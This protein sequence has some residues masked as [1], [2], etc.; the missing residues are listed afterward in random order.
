[1]ETFDFG[2]MGHH[3]YDHA[4][5]ASDIDM[6]FP[7]YGDVTLQSPKSQFARRNM[8]DHVPF[9]RPREPHCE[10]IVP[11]DQSF[12]LIDCLSTKPPCLAHAS[13]EPISA[14]TRASTP[15]IKA[16]DD[17]ASKE[18]GTTPPASAPFGDQQSSEAHGTGVDVLMKAIQ[19]KCQVPERQLPSPP[20]T[21]SSRRDSSSSLDSSSTSGLC[22]RRRSRGKER[23]KCPVPSCGKA[24]TQ[25]G[26]L[27]VHSRAHTGH[28]PYV[29]PTAIMK[30][31]PVTD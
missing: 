3:S 14:W 15:S 30:S 11:L 26:R 17:T 21:V 19:T 10:T 13:E 28:K 1:M 24:F 9:A 5:I 16:E 18:F 2:N 25:K 6:A 20:S 22:D 29:R 27:S 31:L 8:N 12:G 7:W 23:Y 4:M